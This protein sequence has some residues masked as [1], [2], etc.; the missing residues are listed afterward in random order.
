MKKVFLLGDSIRMGYD[1]FVRELLE[2]TAEVFYPE[3]NGRFAGYTYINIPLW[4]NLAGDPGEVNVVHWNCGH[5]DCAH[6]FKDTEPYSTVE[7]YTVWL[8]RVHDC[9]RRS[10]PNAKVIFA[11]TTGVAPGRYEQMA[12]PR[13]NEEI[14]AYNTAA[15]QVMAELGV[16]V[17]DLA[18][19]A[20]GFPLDCFADEVHFTTAGY[21]LLAERV[22]DKIREYL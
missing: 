13:S 1:E 7:E 15:C 12:S 19:L 18:A 11:T 14:A 8:R 17:N 10:F 6:F 5:W 9:I 22:A 2:D 4:K 21:R 20:A 16:P 3:D